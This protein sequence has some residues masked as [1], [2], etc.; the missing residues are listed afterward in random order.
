MTRA[1]NRTD[2]LD[3]PQLIHILLEALR[4]A[5]ASLVQGAGSALGMIFYRMCL[6]LHTQTA[7]ED[8]RQLRASCA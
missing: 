8:L 5:R 6:T 2:D 7:R 3:N 4:Y 1:R